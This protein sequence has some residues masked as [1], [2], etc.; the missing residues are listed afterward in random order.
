M[1]SMD[2]VYTLV[3]TVVYIWKAEV[4]WGTNEMAQSIEEQGLP[5]PMGVYG[6]GDKYGCL[7]CQRRPAALMDLQVGTVP[8]MANGTSHPNTPV[9]L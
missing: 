6:R 2:F 3:Y 8:S 5:Q 1:T 9:P 4:A 7:A